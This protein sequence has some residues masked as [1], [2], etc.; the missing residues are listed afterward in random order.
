[1]PNIPPYQYQP[2]QQQKQGANPLLAA[3]LLYAAYKSGLLKAGA[4]GL[5]S[6]FSGGG[7]ALASTP[8]S[9][10]AAPSMMLPSTGTAAAASTAGA[11]AGAT[12]A[13]NPILPL[14]FMAAQPMIAP[15]AI[16]GISSLGRKLFGKGS[17]AVYDPA[18]ILKN[19]AIDKAG[20]TSNYM[21]SKQVDG[22][23]KMSDA[24]KTALLDQAQKTGALNLKGPNTE[25]EVPFVNWGKY[26][27]P[28]G[29]PITPMGEMQNDKF[30]NGDY[31]PTRQEV[32]DSPYIKNDQRQSLLS[33]WDSMNGKS[34]T[35]T[36]QPNSFANTLADVYTGNKY[37][38]SM[39]K[40][41]GIDLKG[42][43]ISY[44]RR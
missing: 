37:P 38:R 36:S 6:L 31:V 8:V 24:Q 3:P 5:S 35:Q 18:T 11:G 1:M 40:S 32:E 17:T 20:N 19:N 10:F 25:S 30:R 4:S 41:P 39:T 7:S 13:L 44:P 21:I 29:G 15:I 14:A 43:K 9:E 28:Q 33:L 27:K 34:D 16:K 42:Q 2:Q 26:L 22:W 12:A 23:D